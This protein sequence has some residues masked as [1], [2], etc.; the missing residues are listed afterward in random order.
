MKLELNSP[1][2]KETTEI[3]M[4]EEELLSFQEYDDP[5]KTNIYVFNDYEYNSFRLVDS[6][7]YISEFYINDEAIQIKQ[8]DD[9][10]DIYEF[11]CDKSLK[12]DKRIFLQCFGVVRIKVV[13]SGKVYV[14]D[15]ISVMVTNNNHNKNVIE[16]I[17]Y[18][19]DKGEEYLYENY[20]S[21]DEIGESGNMTIE[22]KFRFLD[23]VIEI[24][25]QFFPYFQSS[26]KTKSVVGETIGKFHKLNNVSPKTI[27][28]IASH[29]EELYEVNFNT[30]INYGKRHFQ[31]ENTLISSTSY[32]YDV[33]ENRI[34][35]GFISTII[36]ELENSKEDIRNN[37]TNNDIHIVG[38]YFESKKYIYNFRKKSSDEYMKKINDYIEH[39]QILWFR[40]K[41]IFNTDDAYIDY[42]P[43]YT[44]TFRLVTPYNAVYQKIYEWFQY[45]GHSSAKS[46]LLLSFVSTSKIYEYYCLIKLIV[47][48]REKL[49]CTFIEEKTERFRYSGTKYY[50]NTYCNNTFFFQNSDGIDITLYFQPVIYGNV[51]SSRHDIGLYRN[52][53]ANFRNTNKGNT[54]TPDYLI[55]ITRDGH[56]KYII[57]DAKYSSVQTVENDRLMELVYKY[58]F[59]ISPLD[60]NDSIEGMLIFCGK[61]SLESEPPN[62]HDISEKMK[63]YVTPFSYIVNFSVT[64]NNY[65]KVM[66]S[67]FSHILS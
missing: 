24:Y 43:Q 32:S 2:L 66:K 40:Y 41:R 33:Y 1:L 39:F 23:E 25:E 4:R 11:K 63:K 6:N 27:Q 55:K 36:S 52:R 18:I 37:I 34:I 30:G 64:D 3:H 38:D 12:E 47:T 54:Y 17:N 10:C 42:L 13:I 7:G 19:Y 5:L 61:D 51:T 56:S 21:L 22:S 15:S 46:Q 60:E 59:S 45:G 57:I 65:N 58:L 29:P 49:K 31:P 44:D 16:M 14:S 9:S 8:S 26:P 50:S 35:T 20:I 53:S 62:L 28:Y 48:I 67:V